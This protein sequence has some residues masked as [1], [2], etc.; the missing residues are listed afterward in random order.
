MNENLKNI[1]EIIN[2]TLAEYGIRFA[3]VFGS[4]AR[5]DATPQSDVDILGSLGDKR[6]SLWDMVSLRE[7]LSERLKKPVD[8]VSEG[9][10]IPYFRDSI[11]RDLKIIY[12]TR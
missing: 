2:P 9:A 6:L 3:G 7:E 8:L 1:A 10:V 4:H 12:G 5:G 11:F